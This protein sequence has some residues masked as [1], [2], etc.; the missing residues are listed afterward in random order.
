MKK[1]AD[2]ALVIGIISLVVGMVSRWVIAPVMGIEAHAFLS[3]GMACLLL[4]I[5]VSVRE[6]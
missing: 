4:S 6:K 2:I 1:A 3:F 5:A